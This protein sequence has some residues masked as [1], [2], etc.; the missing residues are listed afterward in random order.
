MRPPR[1]AGY[2]VVSALFLA[3]SILSPTGVCAKFGDVEGRSA[4]S[5]ITFRSWRLEKGG[6]DVTVSQLTFPVRISTPLPRDGLDLVLFTSYASSGVDGAKNET[7]GALTDSRFR[8]NYLMPNERIL[9][10]GGLSL[11]TGPTDL[12]KE[13]VVISRAIS[14]QVLGFRANRYGEGLDLFGSVAAAWPLN[15]RW[16]AGGGAGG[17]LKESYNYAPTAPNG[18]GDVE[19]GSE[20]FLSG[21]VSYRARVGEGTRTFNA[22]LSYRVYGIDRV[23][24]NDVFEEGDEFAFVTSGGVDGE[25]WKLDGFARVVVKGDH[26]FLGSATPVTTDSS[27][28]RVVLAN[29]TSDYQ[30]LRG[31]VTRRMTKKTDITVSL[32]YSRFAEVNVN[33]PDGKPPITVRGDAKVIEP[34]VEGAHRFNRGLAVRAG[35]SLPF[36]DAANGG[37]DLSGYDFYAGLDVR[38]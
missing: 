5:G 38:Q 16:S 30:Q 36:G 11:P 18:L 8:L 35:F 22:D 15:N 17:T 24:S 25:R 21:G 34:G 31:S 6:D 2:A 32:L 26:T 27:L 33:R 7:L 29:V 37:I 4:R 23:E 28:T 12:D 9:F 10:T 3:A 20:F 1:K 19:P 14:N 13:E